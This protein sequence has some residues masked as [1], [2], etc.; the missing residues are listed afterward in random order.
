[1][2]SF[3][4]DPVDCVVNS[5]DTP[6]VKGESSTRHGTGVSGL[7][8]LGT[9]VSGTSDS[10]IGVLGESKS[11]EA[12]RGVSHSGAH[13]AVVGVNDW[14]PKTFPLSGGGNGGWFE[15]NNAEGV[16]GISANPN[17][18]G[19]V[20]VNTAAGIGVYGTSDNGVGVWGISVNSEG[21]HAET[22]STTTAAMAAYQKNAA[23]DTAALYVKHEGNHTAA[24]FEGNIEVTGVINLLGGDIAEDFDAED[25]A[26]IVPGSVVRVG[27]SGRVGVTTSPYDTA[28]VGIVAGAPGFRPALKLDGAPNGNTRLPVTLMGKVMCLVDA[29]SSPVKA[30]DLLTSSQTPGH[31]MKLTARERGFGAV[32]GKAL[33][34]LESGRGLVP[35]LA[36]LR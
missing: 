18:G 4:N 21:I 15:S 33:R 31:A 7:A 22:Q 16:R 26:T 20:G 30:G 28:V 2:P 1:M 5:T 13:A 12:L 23:S 3:P 29:T 8:S 35:I 17:H 32:L 36:T 14:K 10:G 34:P 27:D 25:G 11:N 24:F 6:A 19:V 9:G